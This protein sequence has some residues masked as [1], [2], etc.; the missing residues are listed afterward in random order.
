[1]SQSQGTRHTFQ[2]TSSKDGE[3]EEFTLMILKFE[4]PAEVTLTENH[5]QTEEMVEHE[6]Q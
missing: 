2:L 3:F 6:E 4:A 5:M 1:M